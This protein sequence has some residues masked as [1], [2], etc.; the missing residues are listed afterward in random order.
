MTTG[1]CTLQEI[2][3]INLN[4]ELYYQN[5]VVWKNSWLEIFMKVKN[6]HLNRLQ[7]I[8][9]CS[10]YLWQRF[11]VFNFRRTQLPAKNFHVEFFPNYGI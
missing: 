6:F 7:T 1:S 3:Y 2:K 5:T 11:N 4:V 10:I 8:I 9:N